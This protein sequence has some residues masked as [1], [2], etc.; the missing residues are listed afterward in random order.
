M[1][2][3]VININITSNVQELVAQTNN[4]NQSIN[5]LS[6]NLQGGGSATRSYKQSLA[7][8]GMSYGDLN[9]KIESTKN[10]LK[11]QHNALI[12]GQ[13]GQNLSNQQVNNLKKSI[14]GLE[15]ELTRLTSQQRLYNK[16]LGETGT[17]AQKATS[18]LTSLTNV[19]NKLGAVL[20]VSFGLYGAIRT[21]Q[22]GIKV[23]SDFDL[24]MKKLQSIM[25]E[26][27]QGMQD[28]ALSA[29]NL[30]AASIFGAKG[31]AELQIE[32]AKMG[33]AKNDIMAMQQ[34]IINLAT[35]T[36]EDL[37]SSAE[38]VAGVIRAYQLSASE[39]TRVTDVMGKAF[40]DSA[41]DLANFREAIKY[42]APVAA[43]AGFTFEQT[44][45]TLE[46]LSN[47]GIKGSLAGTGLNNVLKAMMD[48]NS[49][50]SKSLGG[51]VQGYDGFIKV[52]KK[53]NQ[54]G[55]STEQIFGVITQRATAAF[56]T[57]MNG[58][59][60]IERFRTSL[61]NASGVMKEQAAVQLESITYQ[62]KLTKEAFNNLW[63]T[64]DKGD[65]VISK[66][67]KGFLQLVRT[68]M[69]ASGS[70]EDMI[71][72]IEDVQKSL[73][74]YTMPASG[75]KM[76]GT[77]AAFKAFSDLL[78]EQR[79]KIIS[80]NQ[81]WFEANA[82]GIKDLI[83][84]SLAS[85][86][87]FTDK[88]VEYWASEFD[89]N[90][91]KIGDKTKARDFTIQYLESNQ[92]LVGKS[93]VQWEIY[94]KAIELVNQKY[95]ALNKTTTDVEL[96]E[97][98]LNELRKKEIELLE[99]K[100]EL[101]LAQIKISEEGYGEEIKLIQK[102]YEFDKKIMELKYKDQAIFD[103]KMEKL[104]LD[105][106]NAKAELDKKY[107]KP[108]EDAM[109]K[110]Y[111]S[112]VGGM[113]EYMDKERQSEFEDVEKFWDDY[114][115]EYADNV[116]KIIEFGEEHPIFQALFR[117]Q[118]GKAV[119]GGSDEDVKE[120]QNYFESIEDS[121]DLMKDSLGS[122]ADSWV[123]ST[124]RIVEQ[125]NRQVDE[126][127]SA[128]ETELQL[129]EQGYAS[130]VSLRRK[131]LDDV[132]ALRKEAIEDQRKAQKVQL[133]LESSIQVASLIT[134]GYELMKDGVKK[135]GIP[136]LAFGAAA[137]I[138]LLAIAAKF[139]N[140]A[141]EQAAVEYG[142]GGWVEGKSHREGGTPIVAEKGEYVTRR[143]SALKYSKLLEA[144]NKDNELEVNRFYLNN[145][146][147]QMIHASVSLDDSEDLKAIRR[148][149]EQGNK[150]VTYEN[151]WRIE[152]FGSTVTRTR[153]YQN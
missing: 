73:K 96:T 147:G 16:T 75:L 90:L 58:V 52:L 108:Y 29:K 98:E 83:N 103:L 12:E 143:K 134:T 40:N 93:S 79:K 111:D 66:V 153:L 39:A 85:I 3:H 10:R 99:A 88:A 43:Q 68:L 124:D 139:R 106:L 74:L 120:L 84:T 110:I 21:L 87:S 123:E 80:K 113:F 149:M 76:E 63:L 50:L 130:N 89:R 148:I 129:Q 57:F 95:D 131:E 35:A 136:G 51:T 151:G 144:I 30:G 62:A 37:A 11:E 47:V 138:A 14:G 117:K 20:G 41:L 22:Y 128:L 137:I 69:M 100:K 109:P 32:L 127:Q 126:A 46:K 54:E 18:S 1:A 15:R 17:Q 91:K 6:N 146:K 65:G 77:V 102:A 112:A 9:K 97:E 82:A 72:L 26:T 133:A 48:S 135:A 86:T 7:D 107:N 125:L 67:I 122:L 5:N 27:N 25:G 55:W 13:K 92:K 64:L 115:K 70:R 33:F 36:Q 56:T 53:A 101:A 94:A 150:M 104:Y 60:D 38:V 23:I 141:K 116:K 42:V 28:I 2:D 4:L 105:F 145:L 59:D 45:A 31:V 121:V 8:L 71:S 152:R 61:E 24:S 132:K 19:F 78:E 81:F 34:A 114:Y 44:V 119:R 49:K 118:F 140:L 142:E